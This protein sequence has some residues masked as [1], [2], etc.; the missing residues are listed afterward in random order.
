M[1]LAYGQMVK[2]EEFSTEPNTY[3][4]TLDESVE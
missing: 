3:E 2:E 4:V 1:E